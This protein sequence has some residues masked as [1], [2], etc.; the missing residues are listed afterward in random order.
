M[1]TEEIFRALG[2]EVRY[3]LFF[4]LLKGQP[5]CCDLVAPGEDA[6]CVLDFMAK[7][8]LAQSTV[9]HH[10]KI[11]VE[12]KLLTQERRGTFRIYR[13]NQSTW[14]AFV[15]ALGTVPTCC[16]PGVNGPAALMP[17]P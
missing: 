10:L 2:H 12:A 8:P 6:C 3:R 9:S 5:S 15:Q 1:E 4:D 14:Q 7:M 16:E 11:L 13:I 17:D